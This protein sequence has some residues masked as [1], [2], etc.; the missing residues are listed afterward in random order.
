MTPRDIGSWL[1]KR[2]H[3][4]GVLVVLTSLAGGFVLGTFYSNGDLRII[5]QAGPT[6]V[7]ITEETMHL[8]PPF[9]PNAIPTIVPPPC[10]ERL[11]RKY[12]SYRYFSLEYTSDNCSLQL[13]NRYLTE[14]QADELIAER[15]AE[16]QERAAQSAPVDEK[17][18]FRAE[19]AKIRTLNFQDGE[20]VE[21]PDDVRVTDYTGYD[22]FCKGGRYCPISPQYRLVRG[23]SVVWVDGRGFMMAFK[24]DMPEEIDPSAFPFLTDLAPEGCC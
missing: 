22:F 7:V 19:L 8:L 13:G 9:D 6:P 14:S 21:L 11:E 5:A 17:A 15:E 1:L 12:D 24:D 4:A 10:V 2:W 3:I 20:T 18:A 16:N 23:D